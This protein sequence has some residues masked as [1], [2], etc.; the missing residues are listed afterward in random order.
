MAVGDYDPRA[1]TVRIRCLEQLPG[2]PA[3]LNQ[4]G[5]SARTTGASAEAGDCQLPRGDRGV[6]PD[7]GDA[8]IALANLKTYRF[9][10]DELAQMQAQAARGDLAFM[11]TGPPFP[12]FALGKAHED[13]E[14]YPASFAAYDEGNPPEARPDPLQRRRV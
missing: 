8:C 5:P 9:S 7:H 11:E 14:D 12:P 3:N 13:R 2:D 4:Q 10:D 6:G 1:G